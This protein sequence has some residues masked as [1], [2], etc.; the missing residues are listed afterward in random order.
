MD[1]LFYPL[2]YSELESATIAHGSVMSQIVLNYSKID[3]YTDKPYMKAIVKIQ[4][5]PDVAVL[6]IAVDLNSLPEVYLHGYEVIAH[7][8]AHNFTN[9][10]V[11]YTDSNGLEMQKR[12]LNKRVFW[13]ITEYNGPGGMH[14]VTSNYYPINSAIAI[15][16]LEAGTQFTVMNSHA[17]GGASLQDGRIEFMQ[18]R[19]IPSDDNKGEVDWLDEVDQYGNGIRVTATYYL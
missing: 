17:Q 1:H 3:P 18:N 7:F 14:N 2:T 6:N 4:I 13:N 15:K 12:E 8:S 10:G 19:R 5:D 16:D 11:L 9:A